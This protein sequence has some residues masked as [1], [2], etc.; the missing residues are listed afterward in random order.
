MAICRVNRTLKLASFSV[1][2]GLVSTAC[3]EG[4]GSSAAAEENAAEESDGGAQTGSASLKPFLSI[5][6]DQG[7]TVEIYE[8]VPGHFMIGSTGPIGAPPVTHDHDLT[9]RILDIY[10]RLMPG[11]SVP[12]EVQEAQGR[13]DLVLAQSAPLTTE[14][15]QGV[16]SRVEAPVPE[17]ANPEA[18]ASQTD[19]ALAVVPKDPWHDFWEDTICDHTQLQFP[20]RSINENCSVHRTNGGSWNENARHEAYPGCLA[21]DGDIGC[22][23]RWKP[24]GAG[25]SSYQTLWD[26]N[27]EEGFYNTV[28]FWANPLGEELDWRLEIYNASGDSYHRMFMVSWNS[29]RA[30]CFPSGGSCLCP[31]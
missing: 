24:L 13:Q 2:F 12:P 16:D 11:A 10:A 31:V 28:H 22:R 1:L 20:D 6:V 26:V 8:P 17:T 5:P 18:D 9:G 3:T 30:G 25:S 23:L 27:V 15:P 7:R 29:C 14:P 21:Y 4:D 19:E